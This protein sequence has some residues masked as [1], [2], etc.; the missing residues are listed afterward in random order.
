MGDVVALERCL[1][2]IGPAAPGLSWA[3]W[4]VDNSPS[5]GCVRDTAT[6]LQARPLRV[7]GRRGFSTNHNV[8]LREIVRDMVARY[9]LVLNDDVLLYPS[10]LTQLVDHLDAH[11]RTGVAAPRLLDAAGSPVP[12]KV[13]FPSL[14]GEVRSWFGQRELSDLSMPGWLSGACM[15]FTTKAVE[16]VNGFDERFFLFYE[17]VDICLRLTRA[18]YT[19]DLVPEAT[20][21]HIGHQSV[22]TATLGSVAVREYRRSRWSYFVKENQLLT[23]VLL[24]AASWLIA[25]LRHVS[26]IARSERRASRSARPSH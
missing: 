4:V 14:L 19:C 15:L 10:A 24:T 6:K 9:V 7:E 11:L 20:A 16:A 25:P 18:G 21:L 5:E 26:P 8:V 2:A 22:G 3:C 13:S 17:D 12:T 23:A 1:K